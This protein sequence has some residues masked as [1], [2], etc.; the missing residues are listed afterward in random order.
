M[1]MK[2]MHWDTSLQP[3][4]LREGS[5]ATF[6]WVR[7]TVGPGQARYLAVVQA[8]PARCTQHEMAHVLVRKLRRQEK[9]ELCLHRGHITHTARRTETVVLKMSL[10]VC[11]SVDSAGSH[12]VCQRLLSRLRSNGPFLVRLLGAAMV[13]SCS[14][15]LQPGGPF[16]VRLR[17]ASYLAACF[18]SV[19]SAWR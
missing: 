12:G 11:A 16:L 6:R 8:T 18:S 2:V 14:L 19:F 5:C 4:A 9:H 10:E 17:S 7:K 13:F 1:S 3:I 15:L